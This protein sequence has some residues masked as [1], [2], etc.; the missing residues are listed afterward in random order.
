MRKQTVRT[1]DQPV[2]AVSGNENRELGGSCGA[3]VDEMAQIE[4][5][6]GLLP[7]RYLLCDEQDFHRERGEASKRLAEGLTC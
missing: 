6:P 4:D 5:C 7:I 1:H 2:K 3:I